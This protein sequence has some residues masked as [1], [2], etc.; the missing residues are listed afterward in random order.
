MQRQCQGYGAV[1]ASSIKDVVG[2]H[3]FIHF[4]LFLSSFLSF[5][6]AFSRSLSVPFVLAIHIEFPW[7]YSHVIHLNVLE[8]HKQFIVVKI[9]SSPEIA[10]CKTEKM[11]KKNDNNWIVR[12][13]PGT[14]TISKA[15]KQSQW[16]QHRQTTTTTQATTTTTTINKEISIVR[17]PFKWCTN[18]LQRKKHTSQHQCT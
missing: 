1:N 18:A 12:T 7:I 9:T 11:F 5:S 14:V 15:T 10:E 3:S 6:F 4:L 2:V 13:T 8:I 17:V 16:Y